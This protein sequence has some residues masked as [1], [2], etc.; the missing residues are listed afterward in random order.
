MLSL[1]YLVVFVNKKGGFDG[2][3]GMHHGYGF[4]ESL[5]D[6]EEYSP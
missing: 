3:E 1:Y 6:L 2:K 5:E 4:Y